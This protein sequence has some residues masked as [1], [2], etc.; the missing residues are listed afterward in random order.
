MSTA[1]SAKSLEALF[2]SLSTCGLPH[3][4]DAHPFVVDLFARAPQKSKHKCRPAIDEGTRKQAE[5]EAREL[6]TQKYVFLLEDEAKLDVVELGTKPS[7]SKTE[8]GQGRNLRKREHDG[9]E[10]EGDEEDSL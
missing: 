8:E 10:W 6:S 5:Q 1:S 4:P 2:A 3:T 7:G 9:Q